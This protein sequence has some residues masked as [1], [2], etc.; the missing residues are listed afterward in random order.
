MKCTVILLT[1]CQLSGIVS[2][3]PNKKKVLVCN[4]TAR[5]YIISLETRE[6]DSIIRSSDSGSIFNQAVWMTDDKI[7]AC[8]I[9][10]PATR[11]P[12]TREGGVVLNASS[13]ASMMRFTFPG[14]VGIWCSDDRVRIPT[15][16]RLTYTVY[17]RN[18]CDI[19]KKMGSEHGKSDK[20]NEI[21][22]EHVVHRLPPSIEAPYRYVCHLRISKTFRLRKKWCRWGER[23]PCMRNRKRIADRTQANTLLH[24]WFVSRW[25]ANY[26]QREEHRLYI[27][28]RGWWR[29]ASCLCLRI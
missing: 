16:L 11:H 15:D 3:S 7:L 17:P 22:Y 4:D 2:L 28:L 10:H 25:Q 27:W 9:A 1:V 20:H 14:I 12:F 13:G 8:E 23:R 5:L 18:F 21:T 24:A 6:L 19:H 26:D 29:H